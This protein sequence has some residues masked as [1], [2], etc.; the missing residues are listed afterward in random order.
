MTFFIW[1]RCCYLMVCLLLIDTHWH[2]RDIPNENRN[3]DKVLWK[4]LILFLLH[5]VFQD[6]KTPSFFKATD[7]FLFQPVL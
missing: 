3:N 7:V 1:D 6:V 4:K 5:H 2:P